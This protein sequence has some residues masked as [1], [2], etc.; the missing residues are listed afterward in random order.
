MKWR[1]YSF[2]RKHTLHFYEVDHI[3]IIINIDNF[4]ASI[5]EFKF[6]QIII[7]LLVFKYES[8]DCFLTKPYLSLGTP[9]Q[10]CI[11][12]LFSKVSCLVLNSSRKSLLG[13]FPWCQYSLMSQV[14]L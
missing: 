9:K 11:N 14:K 8:S 5:F 12:A 3:I 13:D 4:L 1:E 6:V 7:L 2:P 10:Y